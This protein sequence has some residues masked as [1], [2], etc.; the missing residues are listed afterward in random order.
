MFQDPLLSAPSR[1]S[2]QRVQRYLDGELGDVIQPSSTK[3]ADHR[4]DRGGYSSERVE[5][6]KPPKSIDPLAVRN[7]RG[8][9]GARAVHGCRPALHMTHYSCI[10]SRTVTPI[11]VILGKS[12]RSR[13]ANQQNIV[14]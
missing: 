3:M 9:A 13:S 6:K 8:R 7:D 11:Y 5:P 12:K 14:Y 2:A 10:H 4:G 1:S